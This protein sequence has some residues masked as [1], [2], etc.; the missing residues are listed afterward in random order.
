[1]CRHVKRLKDSN[2]V[3]IV[4]P[5][6]QRCV[7]IKARLKRLVVIKAAYTTDL[8]C[9]VKIIPRYQILRCVFTQSLI[10]LESNR[11]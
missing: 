9:V 3:K 6:L 4:I 7:V 1:M 10:D 11:D 8:G 5:S 2:G